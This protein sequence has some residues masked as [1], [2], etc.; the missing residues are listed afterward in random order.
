MT[1]NAL[2]REKIGVLVNNISVCAAQLLSLNGPDLTSRAL[3]NL[4]KLRR[5][6]KDLLKR[7]DGLA[8]EHNEE[9]PLRL[10][11]D[12]QSA[13]DDLGAFLHL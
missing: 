3:I 10:I 6:Q 4:G 7:L 11:E 2:E 5:E 1:F 13:P 9:M 8:R 12:M